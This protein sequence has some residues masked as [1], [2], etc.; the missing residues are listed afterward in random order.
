MGLDWYATGYCISHFNHKWSLKI[1]GLFLKKENIGLL[2]KGIKSSMASGP[3]LSVQIDTVVL[4]GNRIDLDDEV[5]LKQLFGMIQLRSLVCYGYKCTNTF[6]SLVFQHP[7]IQSLELHLSGLDNDTELQLPHSNTSLMNFTTYSINLRLLA[8]LIL[9]CTSL[10]YLEIFKHTYDNLPVLT[11]IVQSHPSLEILQIS[12]VIKCDHGL[13]PNLLD[14]VE[15]ARN[16]RLK[17]LIL[18]QSDY[19]NLPSHMQ[20]PPVVPL[21]DTFHLF[22]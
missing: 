7:S 15:A 21:Q 13:S 12:D 9:D 8:R 4:L 1:Q 16:S 19:D 2:I 14:L 5:I 20:K 11:N 18:T 10:N 6:L 3:A 22:S 17:S